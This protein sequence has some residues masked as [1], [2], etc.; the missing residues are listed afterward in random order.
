MWLWLLHLSTPRPI[1]EHVCDLGSAGDGPVTVPLLVPASAHRVT[2]VDWF[3]AHMLNGPDVLAEVEAGCPELGDCPGVHGRSLRWEFSPGSALERRLAA[4]LDERAPRV[5]PPC[6]V[7]VLLRAVRE[8]PVTAATLGLLTVADPSRLSGAEQADLLRAAARAATWAATRVDDL[9]LAVASGSRDVVLPAGPAGDRWQDSTLLPE[10]G[11]EDVALAL[12]ASPG[13]AQH[14]LRSARALRDRAPELLAAMR[15]GGS[16]P[17]HARELAEATAYLDDAGAR[18]V[19]EQT[20]PALLT[21]TKGAVRAAARRAAARWTASHPLPADGGLVD[22]VTG[23][24]LP[25][26]PVSPREQRWVDG[27]P[28]SVPGMG[29]LTALLPTEDLAAL[30]A[31]LDAAVDAAHAGGDPRTAM[32][33][34]ADTLAAF[35]WHGLPTQTTLPLQP[36]HKDSG[37]GI[38]DDGPGTGTG[39]SDDGLGSDDDGGSTDGDDGNGSDDANGGG[40]SEGPGVDLEG[41]TPRVDPVRGALSGPVVARVHL[42]LSLAAL[43]GLREDPA[44]L[45]SAAPGHRGRSL[46]L[47]SAAVAR[48]LALCADWQRF[49]HDDN[50]LLCGVSG[51]YALPAELR[52]VLLAEYQ[53]CTAYG[54]PHPASD[55]DADHC[56]PWAPDSTGGLTCLGNLHP[57]CRRHH[58][59]K[60]HGRWQADRGPDGTITWTSPLGQTTTTDPHHYGQDTPA[61]PGD[62]PPPPGWRPPPECPPF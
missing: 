13:S 2:E 44:D 5:G 11:R 57:L 46:G 47:I 14:R 37:G 43:L 8:A 56:Q 7:A 10:P 54:C 25:P 15:H 27:G 9:A 48:R 1:V 28:A 40:G 23:E 60:T 39:G 53:T 32:Q 41:P 42:T 6:R 18:W 24:L 35:G 55:C 20:H 49:L 4:V 19:A 62:P 59:T 30:L 12:H 31:R 36:T 38:S 17:A 29:W 58:N 50:G 16:S 34:R 22:P 52:R 3:P 51:T 61:P 21:G 26:A 33:V 45:A